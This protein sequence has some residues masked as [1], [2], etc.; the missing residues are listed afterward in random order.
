METWAMSKPTILCIASYFK[1]EAF[2]EEA[3]RQGCRVLLLT[4][5][6]LAHS[7]WPHD[8]IDEFHLTPDLSNERWIINT[9][10]YLCR[11][12]SIDRIVPL[13][14][15]DVPMAAALREH[16]Q[17]PG[18][19]ESVTRR[20]R[21]KLAMRVGAREAGLP[22][23]EFVGV[24]NYDRL[25]D[26]MARVPPPW[27]LKPRTEAGAMGIK[28]IDNA[29][30]LWHWLDQLG[31]EQSFFLLEQYLPG[32]VFHV[33]SLV[34]DGAVVFASVQ[35]YGQPPLNV[36]HEGGVFITRTLPDESDDAQALRQ[37][38]D[39]VLRALGMT[40]GATHA[41]YI[42]SHAGGRFYFLEVA[43][44]VGGAHIADLIEHA[45]GIN[46]WT[47]WAR[48]VAADARGKMYRLPETKRVYAGL[49][50][51]L[52]KQEY[53]DLN[54]Y[55]DPEVVWTLHKKN[56]AGLVV[57][58]PDF[59]RMQALLDSYAQRFAVDFLAYAPP[60]DKPTE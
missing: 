59:E 9:V 11:E 39:R 57:A 55:D 28:R 35:Q 51:C 33:D 36:A 3:K 49:L 40:R 44:R 58:S 26:F 6:R 10:S 60:K 42:K 47:E 23:P 30:A 14:E 18:T 29:D 43:A 22:V 4:E 34:W 32:D 45:A 27:L 17:I 25:H 20:F 41:E 48:I 1:G 38:N 56:H 24:L 53:P 54:A 8:S 52:A 2:I 46:L 50:V 13:D 21:D 12:R 37:L 19:G 15:Y 5:E 16:L 7:P 31:D